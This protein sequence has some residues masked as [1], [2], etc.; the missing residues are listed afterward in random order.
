MA[1]LTPPEI[2]QIISDAALQVVSSFGMTEDARL[3]I[4][5]EEAHS[6]VPEWNSAYRR[7][8]QSSSNGTARAILQGRKIWHGMPSY[9]PKNRERDQ[10][11]PE[12]V[13][14]SVRHEDVR[15]YGK[16]FLANYLGR[17]YADV[18]PNLSERHAIFFGRASQCENPVLMRANDRAAFVTA[19]RSAHPPAAPGNN[20]AAARS[21]KPFRVTLSAT[22]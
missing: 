5:Y 16:E 8:Q 20:A 15:R 1:P 2:T 9:H 6:L 3:C 13:Q 14:L 12:P 11:D 4:V 22:L 7:R 18:L 17:S 19:F 10:D 21:L